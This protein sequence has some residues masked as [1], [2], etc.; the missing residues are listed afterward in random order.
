MDLFALNNLESNQNTL[1]FNKN[2]NNKIKPSKVAIDPKKNIDENLSQ[3]Y[4]K[5]LISK[6]TELAGKGLPSSSI[7]RKNTEKFDINRS[8]GNNYLVNIN[9]IPLTTQKIP[10]NN[11]SNIK[12]NTIKAISSYKKI[13]SLTDLFYTRI[14]SS[15]IFA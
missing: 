10:E 4:T 15:E 7:K 1:I 8:F 12:Q 14:E 9:F 3:N 11:S 2:F 13:Q 6:N 5:H